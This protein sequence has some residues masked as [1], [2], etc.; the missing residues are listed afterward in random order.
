MASSQNHNLDIRFKEYLKL[1]CND[2]KNYWNRYVFIDEIKERWFEFELYTEIKNKKKKENNE[3]SESG[4]EKEA[5]LNVINGIEI[6]SLLIYGRPGS[7][8][9][10]LLAKLFYEALLKFQHSG[11]NLIP[12]LIELKSY[13]VV[14][15]SPGIQ[16]LILRTLQNYDPEIDE[17]D[18][19]QAR[20]QK[21][22][23]L[24]ID[25][26]NEL[27]DEKAKIKIKEYCK[28][29]TKI[30]TSRSDNDWREI[31]KKIGIDPLSPQEVKKFFRERLPSS[32]QAELEALGDRVKDFGETPLIVWMLYSIFNTSKE[33]PETRGEAYRRFTNLYAEQAKEGINLNESQTLL[34]K[35][36]FEMMQSCN[37]NTSYEFRPQISEIE[38]QSILGSEA[39]LKILRNCHL[40]NAYGQPG[41]RRI[42]FCHQSLQEYYAAEEIL[43]GLRNETNN[44]NNDEYFQYFFLNR[45]EWTETISLMM[46]LLDDRDHKL[47]LRIIKLA[48]DVDLSLGAKL[49]GD[50]KNTFQNRVISLL[51]DPK[52][53]R[54]V[55][56]GFFKFSI[57]ISVPYWLKITLWTESRSSALMEKWLEAFKSND[58]WVRWHAIYGLRYC[59]PKKVMPIFLEAL[60]D[61]DKDIRL[62]AVRGLSY[63]DSST[64]IPCLIKATR[65]EEVSV[66]KEA[67]QAICKLRTRDAIPIFH[68]M[69]EDPSGLIRH[70]LVKGLSQLD[71]QT[72]ISELRSL[73][74]NRS[75]YPAI[76]YFL[77]QIGTRE[78]FRILVEA[79]EIEDCSAR[80]YAID[81]IGNFPSEIAIYPLIRIL[82]QDESVSVRI[83]A[84]HN[85]AKFNREEVVSALTLALEQEHHSVYLAS[86]IALIK[87]KPEIS[88]SRLYKS[89]ASQDVEVRASTVDS[90]KEVEANIKFPFLLKA[91]KDDDPFIRRK[92]VLALGELGRRSIEALHELVND[93]DRSVRQIAALTLADQGVKIGIREIILMLESIE[94][95]EYQLTYMKASSAL[96]GLGIKNIITDLKRFIEEM[97]LV[98]DSRL[99]SSFLPTIVSDLLLCLDGENSIREDAH[100]LLNRIPPENMILGLLNALNNSNDTVSFRASNALK[101]REAHNVLAIASKIKINEENSMIF[102]SLIE[103]F[104]KEFDAIFI[105]KNRNFNLY[106]E[107]SADST[108]P[109]LCDFKGKIK[110]ASVKTIR[111][112]YKATNKKDDI[113]LLLRVIQIC[114]TIPPQQS[115]PILLRLL[116]N[117]N[118]IISQTAYEK[119]ISFGPDNFL[120]QLVGT[121]SKEVNLADRNR[122]IQLLEYTR[123]KNAAYAASLLSDLLVSSS[124]PVA[125]KSLKAIQTNCKIYNYRIYK[126]NLI[127]VKRQPSA[128]DDF[129][130][131]FQSNLPSMT[132]LPKNQPIFN[133]GNVGNLNTGNVTIQ[134]DQIGIQNNYKITPELQALIAEIEIAIVGLKQR[135]STVVTEAQALTIIDSEFIKTQDNKA[136]KLATLRQQIL[137][138]ERHL[139]ASKATLVE[140]L[141]HYLEESIWAKALITYIDTL[142]TNPE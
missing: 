70:D 115:S 41:N 13:E 67:V 81:E 33:I 113:D 43:D 64:M 121:I 40:L 134:G 91:L 109:I 58:S 78:A 47:M 75:L 102:R 29:I 7:G 123:S 26:F 114:L 30:V 103:I 48:L 76:T 23:L 93:T 141:K 97:E 1:A 101:A 104:P 73:I 28:S 107:F 112:L 110:N 96:R 99:I 25:G 80:K 139:Q 142:S 122:A 24:L 61:E 116:K 63:I 106:S 10:T 66:R 125:F 118:F 140:I 130:S 127:Q 90:L 119:L 74:K 53:C 92:T 34:R 16:G 37:S 69:I 95:G 111:L 94:D 100:Y 117:K 128:I 8:K 18:L 65:D 15:E 6:Q 42:Q 20:K 19:K 59:E 86:A 49:I 87:F 60:D 77:G 120:S 12:V 56:I 85:L 62:A 51:F 27:T 17:N 88:L 3:S 31:E 55:R 133:I 135:N 68:E 2:Y 32:S 105:Q 14:G 132:Q 52:I 45:L 129:V 131:V 35:L 4:T 46:S 36:A 11:S 44:F 5:I 57:R 137:N 89:L 38:A 84:V 138:P 71:S 72:A 79:L 108:V 136:S 22:L 39:T 54:L 50:I 9:S 124:G 21:R 83:K 98:E 126:L 82:N